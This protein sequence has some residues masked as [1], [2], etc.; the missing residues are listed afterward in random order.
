MSNGN[1]FFGVAGDKQLNI[2]GMKTTG[3]NYVNNMSNSHCRNS[4][5]LLEP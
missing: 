1:E 2:S 3:V 4:T 5:Q